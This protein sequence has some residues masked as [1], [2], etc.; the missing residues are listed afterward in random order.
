ML[1]GGGPD[2]GSGVLVAFFNAS[3]VGGL[4]LVD[5]EDGE[6]PELALGECGEESLNQI[7]PAGLFM[8]TVRFLEKGP[9]TEP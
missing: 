7:Y 6:A 1:D 2:E 9:L 3:L 5:A 4:E 8:T